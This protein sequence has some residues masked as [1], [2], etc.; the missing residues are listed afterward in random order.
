[1]KKTVNLNDLKTDTTHAYRTRGSFS[2]HLNLSKQ[3]THSDANVQEKAVKGIPD[4]KMPCKERQY[5][6][7]EQTENPS[8][9]CAHA[10]AVEIES[11]NNDGA[12]PDA[13]CDQ[14]M[15]QNSAG[16]AQQIPVKNAISNTSEDNVSSK[17]EEVRFKENKNKNSINNTS[18]TD[19]N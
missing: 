17:I 12:S 4:L 9:I 13:E 19:T 10:S 16:F 18:D 3:E 14:N 1:M 2:S 15:L 8:Y 6:N 7:S 5:Y 11:D